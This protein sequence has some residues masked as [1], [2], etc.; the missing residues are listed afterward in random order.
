MLDEDGEIKARP[1][2]RADMAG[3]VGEVEPSHEIAC[4]RFFRKPNEINGPSASPPFFLRLFGSMRALRICAH[5][6]TIP[7]LLMARSP[8]GRGLLAQE[9]ERTRS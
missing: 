8:D 3:A 7:D 9:D 5:R 2:R 4:W 1:A 6:Q